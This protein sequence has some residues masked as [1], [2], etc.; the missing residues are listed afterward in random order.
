MWGKWILHLPYRSSNGEHHAL[1]TWNYK[2]FCIVECNG[3]ILCLMML[4]H[5]FINNYLYLTSP[6]CHFQFISQI[7]SL[8]PDLRIGFDNYSRETGFESVFRNQMLLIVDKF[9][10]FDACYNESESERFT[11]RRMWFSNLTVM[12]DKLISLKDYLLMHISRHLDRFQIK[13]WSVNFV[14]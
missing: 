12:M 10:G 5:T 7:F 3:S 14:N 6:L 2:P 11:R 8:Q 4:F 1:V 13:I 9:N